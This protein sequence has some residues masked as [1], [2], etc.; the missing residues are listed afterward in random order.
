MPGT[1]RQTHVV[2]I[3][4]NEELSGSFSVFDTLIQRINVARRN[5]R[6]YV[7]DVGLEKLDETMMG[8]TEER[9]WS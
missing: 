7:T 4:S 8:E 9:D 5:A 1:L 6:D 2:V 3:P